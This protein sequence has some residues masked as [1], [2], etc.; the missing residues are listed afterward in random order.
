[1][2][3]FLKKSL[4]AA[5]MSSVYS[6]LFTGW[7]GYLTLSVIGSI[8]LSELAEPEFFGMIGFALAWF[9]TFS[10]Q[11]DLELSESIKSERYWLNSRLETIDKEKEEI[12]E[13][14]NREINQIAKEKEGAV[15]QALSDK[16]IYKT[17]L[18]ERASGYPTLIEAI[19]EFEEI[20][21]RKIEE[22]LIYKKNPSKKGAEV[23]REQNQRRRKAEFERKKTMMIIEHYENLAPF[24]LDYKNEIELPEE[25]DILETYSEEEQAD[26][27]TQ[28]LTKD[29][30]RNLTTTERNQRAL[31]R[32]W[33]RPKSKWHIGK[34]YERYIGH[35]YEME[36]YEVE[37]SGIK[38]RLEDL[39]RDLIAKKDDEIVV[40]QCKNW[41]QFR[42]IHENSVFQFFGTVFQFREE[43]PDKKV[44]AVFYCTNKLSPLASNFAKALKIE[45]KED[46]KMDRKYPC[47][48]C[49]ISRVDGEKI[50]HMPFDQQYDNVTI[51][52]HRNEFFCATVAEAEQA[53]FRRA[54]K[55]KWSK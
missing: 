10:Y 43:N 45:L 29:E 37:Y 31:D 18:V 22:Y 47:I 24:L 14:A 33:T 40:I 39:G 54:F 16:E 28:F 5:L 49:N 44:K 53:G 13:A 7:I 3:D 19:N 30:F 46:F 52:P 2:P 6:F 34:M 36:G 1:M 9:I 48:K 17:S 27:V 41:S 35:L 51:E 32:Y 8:F 21:D 15:A 20:R 38:K 12:R 55:H 42:K 4:E 23:V 11:Y 25:K 50:Y 26:V